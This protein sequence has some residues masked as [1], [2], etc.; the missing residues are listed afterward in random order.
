MD[1][2]NRT[3]LLIAI[4]IVCGTFTQLLQAQSAG[5]LV[6]ADGRT[7]LPQMVRNDDELVI[8]RPSGTR[9]P[10]LTESPTSPHTVEGDLRKMLRAEAIFVA[11]VRDRRSY[12]VDGD[13][14]IRS[15]I[16]M[17]IVSTL[18]DAQPTLTTADRLLTFERNSGEIR[19]G[20]AVVR[21]GDVHHF[22]PGDRYL[23]GLKRFV[24]GRPPVLLFWYRVD[25]DGKLVK[26]DIEIMD[27]QP[28]SVLYGK[29]L[30]EVISELTKLIGQ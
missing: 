15:S 24:A 18:R 7:P 16:Q 9:T 3:V 29:Q 19:V 23:V 22:G 1:K 28:N 5:R 13:T 4:V 30:S 6:R 17:S 14:W 27:S 26:P 12:L 10:G 2:Y 11:D 8:V 21:A 25:R 20:K